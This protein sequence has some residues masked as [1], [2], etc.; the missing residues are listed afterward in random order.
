M[1]VKSGTQ[2][3][4][5]FGDLQKVTAA[6]ADHNMCCALPGLH[7]FTGCDTVSTFAEKGKISA[8]KLMQKNRKYQ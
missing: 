5:K 3:R 4:E 1:Y 6:A 8:L 2:T 7:S